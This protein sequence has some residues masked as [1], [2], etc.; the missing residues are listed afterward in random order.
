[1]EANKVKHVKILDNSKKV[2]DLGIA[3]AFKAPASYTG[4]DMVEIQC[5]GSLAVVDQITES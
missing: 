3:F 5:H 4:E 1:M 2:I